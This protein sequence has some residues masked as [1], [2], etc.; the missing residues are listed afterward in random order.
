MSRE[1]G[2]SSSSQSTGDPS[3]AQRLRRANASQLLALVDEHGAQLGIREVRQILLN[4]FATGA[5]LEA[6][7]SNRRLIGRSEIRSALC[8]DP[9]APQHRALQ[10]LSG[11]FWRDLMEIGKNSR[12]AAAVRRA[13]DRTLRQ[14]LPRLTTGEKITLARGAVPAVLTELFH[15]P[16]PRVI[17]ALLDNPRADEETIVRFAADRA[18]HPRMLLIVAEDPRWGRR[19]EVRNA[20]CRNPQ[21]PLRIQLE[22]LEGLLRDDLN[23]VAEL[24]EHSSVVR[25]RAREL[26][27]ERSIGGTHRL[28]SG[29]DGS[30]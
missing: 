17:R 12:M 18:L 20:L 23:A 21:A 15:D 28:D 27:E 16:N 1:R 24:D 14:R 11:L 30:D 2:A 10:F 3:L 9:R 19:Y 22:L 13:A 7:L 26:L 29:F 8:R 4:P 25:Q 6:L 5:V